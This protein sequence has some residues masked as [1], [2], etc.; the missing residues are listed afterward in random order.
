MPLL[1][2]EINNYLEDDDYIKSLQYYFSKYENII[3]NKRSRHRNKKNKDNNK[4]DSV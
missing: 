1:K 2:D 4:N 3:N